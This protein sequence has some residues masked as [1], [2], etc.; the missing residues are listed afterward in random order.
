M[1]KDKWH[2]TYSGNIGYIR[3]NAG[4]GAFAKDGFDK[5]EKDIFGIN[6]GKKELIKPAPKLDLNTRETKILN[7]A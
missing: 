6:L 5:N 4:T 3:F 7:S 1:A 2:N